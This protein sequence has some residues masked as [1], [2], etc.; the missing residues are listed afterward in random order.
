MR[1]EIEGLS[2]VYDR[3]HRDPTPV[4]DNLD[5]TIE[6]GSVHALVGPSGCGKSTL[7]RL[8]AGLEQA[9]RGAIE[10]VGPRVA[11]QRTAMVFQD[12]SLV[13]WWTV[14]RNVGIGVEFDAERS[15]LHD[16]I[17]T[18]NV[19]RV[20]LRGLARRM[21]HSLS[22]GEKTK[23]SIGRAMA[24]DADVT[25]LDEPFTHLDMLSKRRF[26]GEFETHWHLDQRTYV[27][28]THDVEEAVL[29][30]DRVSVFSPPTSGGPS[31]IVDTIDVGIARPRSSERI[32]EPAYRS[33]IGRV[34]DALDSS[35]A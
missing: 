26:W 35:S 11:P 34:W 3:A 2:F 23:T 21:A 13:P 22:R 1:V 30:A 33:A 17:T 5:L 20:G 27:L 4:F 24:Y 10:F 14:G 32:T 31:C 12:P 19:D 16:K 6:A 9:P 28:V 25:L 7:L 18:F 8:I 15:A 29:L